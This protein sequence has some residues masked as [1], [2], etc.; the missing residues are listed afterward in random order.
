MDRT[1]EELRDEVMELDRGSQRR[2]VDEVEHRWGNAEPAEADFEE[3]YQ[4][5]EAYDRG[6]ITAMSAEESLSLVNNMISEA[7]RGRS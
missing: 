3:A 5:L 7:R 1:Y 4:R 2:L 6:E